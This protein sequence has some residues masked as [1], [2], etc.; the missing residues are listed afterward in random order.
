MTDSSDAPDTDPGG[1]S[2]PAS[3]P[4][5]MTLSQLGELV[6]AAVREQGEALR[7]DLGEHQREELRHHRRVT[8]D[9][10]FVIGHLREQGLRLTLLER[11]VARLEAGAQSEPPS[12]VDSSEPGGEG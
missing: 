10:S 12:H 6:L 3:A 9:L 5:E 8:L 11:R 1:H 4:P 2:P 7:R